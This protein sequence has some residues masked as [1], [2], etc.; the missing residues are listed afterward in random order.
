MQYQQ[1][2]SIFVT[3]IPADSSVA[4][5][6][7]YFGRFGW[8]SE[9]STQIT[10]NRTRAFIITPSDKNSYEAILYPNRPHYFAKRFLQCAP[11]ETGESLLKHNI[12]NNKKRVIVKRVPS[13]IS[14]EELTYWL[15]QVAGPVQSMFAYSTDDAVKRIA[16]EQRK[17]KT[18][19]VI[20]SNIDAVYNIL[21]IGSFKFVK[22]MDYT[23]IERFRPP[24]EIN[25]NGGAA[26]GSFANQP[27]NVSLRF[28]ENK[29]HS[30]RDFESNNKPYMID[31]VEEEGD[32]DNHC[33]SL[34]KLS[35]NQTQPQDHNL[36][37]GIKPCSKGYFSIAQRNLLNHVADEQNLQFKLLKPV[38]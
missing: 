25:H 11:Y 7:N 8:L 15:E 23:I 27:T 2:P 17:Y 29:K 35:E 3:G 16:N 9:V 4:E 20:F 12:R 18:Y 1:N 37:H 21:Q 26:V 36:F 33:K 6:A 5:V 34:K 19:S 24:R 30:R 28:K 32:G 22:G 38:R 10:A 31:D 14:S 13:I